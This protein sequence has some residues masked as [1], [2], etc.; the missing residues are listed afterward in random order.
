MGRKKKRRGQ[1]TPVEPPTLSGI[2]LLLSQM[3]AAKL[4]LHGLTAHQAE[5][6]VQNFLMT[7]MRVSCGQVVHIITGKGTRSEGAA[8]LPGVVRRLL[9]DE[10]AMYVDELAG[11]PGGG[12]FVVRVAEP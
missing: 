8:V 5:L 2:A 3:P 7:Q 10:L 12:G 6:R 1:V 9:S 4:D 11:L